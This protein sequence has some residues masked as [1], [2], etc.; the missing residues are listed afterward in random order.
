MRVWPRAAVNMYINS[1]KVTSQSML[2]QQ[3]HV[4]V[5]AKN[6]EKTT[7]ESSDKYFYRSFLLPERPGSNNKSQ[8]RILLD[9][10]LRRK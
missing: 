8:A 1:L 7:N 2:T 4:T 10:D 6:C 3:W 9:N 5:L